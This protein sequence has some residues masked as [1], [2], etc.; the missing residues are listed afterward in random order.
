MNFCNILI[1][2]SFVRTYTYKNINKTVDVV[3][4]MFIFITQ[5][6]IILKFF[7]FPY[8]FVYIIYNANMVYY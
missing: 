8:S 3:C 6:T 2:L 1:N 4:F 7:L 5:K